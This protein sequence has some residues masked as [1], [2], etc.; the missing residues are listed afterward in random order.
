MNITIQQIGGVKNGV[1]MEDILGE[2][3]RSIRAAHIKG[4]LNR[5]SIINRLSA[6]D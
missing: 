6:M 4:L 1:H 3:D 5:R 2:N